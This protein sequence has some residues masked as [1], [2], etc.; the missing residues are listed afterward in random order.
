[1]SGRDQGRCHLSEGMSRHWM[2][3][4]AWFRCLRE[5]DPAVGWQVSTRRSGASGLRDLRGLALGG[6]LAR[7]VRPASDG[8][9]LVHS[10]QDLPI[11]LGLVCG[12]QDLP[13]G[14][15][16]RLSFAGDLLF[17]PKF[18]RR[19]VLR[20]SGM[21]PFL[22]LRRILSFLRGEFLPYNNLH[23]SYSNINV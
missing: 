22:V 19:L 15:R 23:I 18:G 10:L 5:A 8:L 7:Y 17:P 4:S 1:M 14:A 16:S 21:I 11:G 13:D 3:R 9:G 6:A 20:R 2:A 12:S